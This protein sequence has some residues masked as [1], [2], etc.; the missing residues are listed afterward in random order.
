MNK[1]F[2]EEI[3]TKNNYNRAE[4]NNVI[5]EITERFSRDRFLQNFEISK[6]ENIL[7]K[8]NLNRSEL[9]E[10]LATNPRFRCDGQKIYRKNKYDIR[11]ES[12]LIELLKSRREGVEENDELYDCYASC[13]KDIENMKNKGFL[14]IIDNKN[15]KK[16]YLFLKDE[17]QDLREF[18]EVIEK[19]K[20]KWNEVIENEYAT[21]T[22]EIE[23]KNNKGKA[24][25]KKNRKR[26]NKKIHN[27]WMK[28]IID[29]SEINEDN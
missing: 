20:R 22:K 11:N 17:R 3:P 10:A 16:T 8:N 13:K 26:K 1:K 9:K 25:R 12:E 15:E 4:I 24:E 23:I 29:F 2:I 5:R 19:L 7:L 27:T 6:L 18:Q 21:K 28:G 14:R